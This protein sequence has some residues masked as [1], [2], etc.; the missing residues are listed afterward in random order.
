VSYPICVTCGLQYGSAVSACP[1]CEDPRQYVPTTGQAWTTLEELR[2]SHRNR[3]ADDHGYLGIGTTPKFGIGQRA[4][5]VGDVLWDCITLLDDETA[6]RV[7]SLRAIAISHPHYYSSMVEWGRTFDCPVLV[8][9]ADREWVPRPDPCLELW[10]G[11]TY[12]LG[13]GMTLIRC[14]GHFPGGTV[15][16]RG[17]DLFAGDIVQVIPDRKWVAFMYS[18]PNYI[19]LPADSVRAVG[20]ALEPYAF[21]R[22]YG[23]WWDAVIDSDGSGIVRRSVERYV[24]ALGGSLP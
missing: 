8:H 24:A 13:A 18:F 12:D 5:L 19:P 7:G 20:A 3:F 22:I 16:H 10:S 21:E 2:A 17:Q 1:V 23:A 4:L 9:E 15:L 11:E 14:G 6:E